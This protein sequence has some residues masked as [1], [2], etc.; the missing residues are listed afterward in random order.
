[1]ELIS[2]SAKWPI[3]NQ[4]DETGARGRRVVSFTLGAQRPEGRN[5]TYEGKGQVK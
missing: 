4:G 5:Q 3:V 1:M 2:D